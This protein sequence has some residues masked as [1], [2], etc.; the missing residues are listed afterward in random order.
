MDELGATAPKLKAKA[1]KINY[2]LFM[3][4]RTGRAVLEFY[5]NQ[6]L[7]TEEVSFKYQD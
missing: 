6:K 1:E 2:L 4:L 5:R 3:W 7:T